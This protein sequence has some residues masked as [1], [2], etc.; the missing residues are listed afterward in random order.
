[1]IAQAAALIIFVG[2]FVLI[3]LDKFERQWIT[4]VSGLLMLIV[5]FG[6]CLHSPQAI[7]DT[8]NLKAFFAKSFWYGGEE[9]ASAGINWSTI[10]FIAGMMIMVEGMARAGFFRWLCLKIASLVHYRT[11]P[12]FITFMIMS[13]ILAM[14]I[15]SI[16]VILFL[17]AV[18]AAK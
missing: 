16:T 1:M 6:I 18:S 4:L 8:L 10:V 13:A 9:S 5:V 2:M 17:A 3:I 14:F 11:I 15:D 12:I 7:V